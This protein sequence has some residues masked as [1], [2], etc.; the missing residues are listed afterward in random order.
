MADILIPSL[1]FIAGPTVLF[2]VSFGLVRSQWQKAADNDIP[3]NGFTPEPKEN[4]RE[5]MR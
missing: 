1:F 5:V 2:L 3:A 4:A